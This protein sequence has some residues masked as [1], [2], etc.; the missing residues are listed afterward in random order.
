MNDD[1]WLNAIRKFSRPREEM[2]WRGDG[3]TGGA[4]E[5]SRELKERAKEAPERFLSLLARFP[6][7]TYQDFAWGITA[8]IAE[9]KPDT[10]MIERVLA[11][12]DA[13]P[14]ARPDDRSLIW[15]IRAC[16][17]AHGPRAESL[18]LT[19]ATGDDDSTGIGDIKHGERA[20]E[21]DW[22]R[23]FTLGSDLNGKAI[24]SARGSALEMLGG[25]C[26]S[27]KE[28]FEKYRPIL[29]PIIGAPAAA[30]VHSSLSGLLMSALKHEGKQGIDWALRIVRACPEAFYTN[31]GQ[32]IVGWVADLD[33]ASFAELINLYLINQDP[34]ERGFAALAVFQH[35]LDDPE[36][37]PLAEN[38]LESGA[39]YRSAAAAVAAANF[40]SVRFG[41]TGTDWLIRLFDDEDETVRHE[42]SDCFRRMRTSDI[43][44]HAGL[45]EAYV[46][47]RYFETDRTYFLHRLEHAPPGLDELVLKLLE[48]TIKAR[49]EGNNDPRAYELSEIGELALK[50]YASNVDHPPRRTRARDLIDRLVEDGLMGIQKRAAA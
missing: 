17:G 28:T 7:G 30:H 49:T 22:K 40:E 32:Q 47:S 2:R 23:A 15:M 14:A 24:N 18:L 46:A 19:V 27:S 43:A 26:W 50:L 29:D 37:L 48:D 11:I 20:K 41:T 39:N 34:L 25:M 21:P 12:V 42:A 33:I 45:F 9:T 31:N 44:S 10:D 16:T 3:L 4:M 5:L 8:G 38:L 13:N 1:A 35:S 36:W 6:E